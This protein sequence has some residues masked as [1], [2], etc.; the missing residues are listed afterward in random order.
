[1]ARDQRYFTTYYAIDAINFKPADSSSALDMLEGPYLLLV[2]QEAAGCRSICRLPRRRRFSV[3]RN[4]L[5][6][7]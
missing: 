1:M 7:R 3:Q 2:V 5:R 6:L 4:V